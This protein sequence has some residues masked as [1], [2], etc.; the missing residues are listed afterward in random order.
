MSLDG[1]VKQALLSG[2]SS[3]LLLTG[4]HFLIKEGGEEPSIPWHDCNAEAAN[5]LQQGASGWMK[6][7]LI[8][9]LLAVAHIGRTGLNF[10][11]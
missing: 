4:D 6:E 3:R 2:N 8:L 11:E 1:E 5:F 9:R 7:L 10:E